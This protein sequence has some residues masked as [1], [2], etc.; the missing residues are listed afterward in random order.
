MN[1]GG[2]GRKLSRYG[3]R[4]NRALARGQKN[5]EALLYQVN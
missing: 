2:L 4:N 1:L 5:A 3:I